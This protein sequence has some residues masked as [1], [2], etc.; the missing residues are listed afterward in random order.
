M[1]IAGNKYLKPLTP[2]LLQPVGDQV[3]VVGKGHRIIDIIEALSK[4]GDEPVITVIAEKLALN[5][6]N[7]LLAYPRLK[8]IEK[9]FCESDLAENRLV[10]IVVDDFHALV[11]VRGAKKTVARQV[12]SILRAGA[13]PGSEE[14]KW[15]SLATKLILAFALMVVGHIIISYLPLPSFNAIITSLRPYFDDRF[16]LFVLTGFLA[17]MVDG[18]LSMGYGVTSATCLMSFGINPVAVSAAIHTS[19]VFT[20][21]IS[22]YSHYRFGNVNKKLFRHLVIPGVAGAILGAVL[23]VFLGEKAGRWLLPLVALYAM[24]LGFRI[25]SKAFAKTRVE[26]KVKRVGWLAWIGGFLD[27]FG[28]GGWGPI[29]TTTLISKGRS[30]KYTIGSVSLTEFFITMASAATFFVTTGIGYW[31]VVLG[32]LA[33]GAIAAPLAARLAG[34]LPKKTLMIA[35]GLMVIVWCVRMILKSLGWA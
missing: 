5:T 19:E 6:R 17:Q 12:T 35:V 28:G 7:V 14:R 27:S 33:G 3:M 4:S 1:R 8:L 18:I 23:L 9:K 24:F 11:P 10:V 20:S 22:G 16:L 15:K 25:L 21:G 34:K 30:P 31:N 32:L 2:V 13:E 29:V 26:S